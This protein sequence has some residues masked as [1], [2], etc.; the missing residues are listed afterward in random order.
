[1]ISS[2][3]KAMTGGEALP[4]TLRDW[5]AQHGIEVYQSYATADLG[6]VAYET[7][8]REGLV[9][10]EGVIVEIVRPGTGD[11]VADGEVGEVVVT[12]FNPDYPMIR[13]ATGDMS[14]VA[15]R[16]ID[17]KSTRLNSSHVKI[18]YAVFCLKKKNSIIKARLHV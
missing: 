17:R 1:D 12:T 18:S 11:P 3:H 13:L 14:A 5:F 15:S 8:A 6:L 16:I 10:D 4:P 9:A 7:A 2:M